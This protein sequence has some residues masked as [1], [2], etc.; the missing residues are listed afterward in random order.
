VPYFAALVEVWRACAYGKRE[1]PASRVEELAAGY[2]DAF[3]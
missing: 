1:L 3:A 2:R